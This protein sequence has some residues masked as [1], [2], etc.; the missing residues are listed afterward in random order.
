MGWLDGASEWNWKAAEKELQRGVELNPNSSFAHMQYALYLVTTGQRA[1]AELEI[2]KTLEL[3]PLSPFNR[4]TAAYVFT[5]MRQYDRGIQEAHRAIE[6]DPTFADA[7]I[8]LAEALGTKGLYQEG[9]SEWLQ[10]LNLSGDAKLAEQLKVA[11]KTVSSSEDPGRNLGHI[12]LRYFQDKSRTRYVAPLF[13]AGAYLD[14]GDK[15]HAL[16]WLDKAYRE[17]SSVLFSIK[18]DP[19]WDPLRSDPRFQDLLRR[20]N[21]PPDAERGK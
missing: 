17:R 15:D 1:R 5:C 14:L 18:V 10:Y 20:M 6:I 7:H 13:I 8:N 3:D 9:F 19:S 2:N 4:S 11:A 16:E 12:A 21:F